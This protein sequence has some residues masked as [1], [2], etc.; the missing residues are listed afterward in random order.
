MIKEHANLQKQMTHLVSF[1][2]SDAMAVLRGRTHSVFDQLWKD[3]YMTRTQA[4]VWLAKQMNLS[5]D[6]AHISLFDREQCLATVSLCHTYLANTDG[7]F[8]WCFDET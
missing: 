2:D 3:K 7:M 5:P 6:Q 4:Y 8:D 1:L